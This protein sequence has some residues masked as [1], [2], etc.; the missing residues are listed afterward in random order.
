MGNMLEHANKLIHFLNARE[1]LAALN[2]SDRTNT[3]LI[4]KKVLTM[5]NFIQNLERKCQEMQVE[6]NSF[7][8]KFIVLQ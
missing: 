7:T 3:I 8:E 2:I 1:K 4:I 6:T 5:R